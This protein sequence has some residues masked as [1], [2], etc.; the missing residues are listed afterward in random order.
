MASIVWVDK[1]PYYTR[2]S[3]HD[4]QAMADD[5]KQQFDFIWL[6]LLDKGDGEF[7]GDQVMVRI[8]AISSVEPHPRRSHQ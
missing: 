8:S 1:A 7:T 4:I 3:Q 2:H 6:D 5:C